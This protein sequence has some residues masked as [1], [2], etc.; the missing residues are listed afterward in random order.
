[1]SLTCSSVEQCSS[2]QCSTEQ[3]NTEQWESGEWEAKR[4][5]NY[6][7]ATLLVSYFTHV[8]T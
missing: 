2:E 7:V 3:C 5:V 6:S 4:V 1:M 8:L